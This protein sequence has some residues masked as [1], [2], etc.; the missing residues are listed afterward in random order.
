MV[1]LDTKKKDIRYQ[2]GEKGYLFFFVSHASP[3]KE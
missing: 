1:N 3:K 2:D